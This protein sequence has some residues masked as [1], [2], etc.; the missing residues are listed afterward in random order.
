M[1]KSVPSRMIIVGLLATAIMPSA[2]TAARA[3]ADCLA[4]PN[5]A[6]APGGHWYYHLD[7]V[8][9]RKCWYLV[10][11][12]SPAPSQTPGQAPMAEGSPPAPV[13]P[14]QPTF[15]SFF[16]TLSTGFPGSTAATPAV[17]GSDTRATP[18]GPADDGTATA[19]QPRMLRRPELQSVSTPKPHRPA[20]VQPRIEQ[21]A[22]RPADPLNQSDR[23]ALFQE[24]LRWRD[25]RTTQP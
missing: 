4:D 5:H 3:A 2:N 15:G 17:A 25:H 8:N 21:A 11:P 1:S 7:R 13:A 12:A 10:E 14:P 23:D 16:S 24:F 19:G 22:D 6:P 9:D 20:H 18:T